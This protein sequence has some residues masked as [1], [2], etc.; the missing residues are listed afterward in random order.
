MSPFRWWI[1]VAALLL[2]SLTA[3]ATILG[4]FGGSSFVLDLIANFRVQY[5]WGGVVALVVLLTARWW[6]VAIIVGLTV[7]LNVA[8]IG[9]YYWSSIAEPVAGSEELII[10]HLNTQASNPDKNLVIEYLQSSRADVVF[11]SEVTPDLLELIDR[12]ETPFTEVAGT[13]QRTPNGILALTRTAGIEGYLTN[14]GESRLPAVVVETRLGE[15]PIEILGL[16]TSSPGS[17]DRARGRDD[18]LGGTAAWAANS[19][20]PVVVIG[21]LNSTP[22]TRAFGSLLNVGLKDGQRGRGISGSWPAGWGVLKIPIDHALHSEDLTTTRY[23]RGTAAG[24]DHLSLEI[25]V[26]LARS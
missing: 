8:L 7:L 13:P 26:A 1:S 5:L 12:T 14:L 20:V 10:A 21:D 16:H 9:P 24:S 4:F 18:Q 25:S 6:G 2:G 17:P 22:F 3:L 19:D 15:Q 23:H 11:L